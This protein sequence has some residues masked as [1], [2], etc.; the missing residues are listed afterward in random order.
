VVGVNG[1]VYTVAIYRY[2]DPTPSV[3]DDPRRLMYALSLV[4]LVEKV[5]TS[6]IR[7]SGPAGY[8][9]R[10]AGLITIPGPLGPMSGAQR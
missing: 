7:G 3:R 6:G 8:G 2:L 5:V 1:A 9:R 4:H 10:C